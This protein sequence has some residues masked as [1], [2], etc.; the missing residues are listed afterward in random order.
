MGNISDKLQ[1]LAETKEAI[2]EA[3]KAKGVTID[4]NAPFRK[5]A[6]SIRS[7][8]AETTTNDV[9]LYDYDGKCLYSYSAEAFL[10]LTALPSPPYREGKTAEWNWALSD[11]QEVVRECGLLDIGVQYKFNDNILCKLYLS[12]KSH[13]QLT[14]EIYG[15]TQTSRIN[16]GDGQEIALNSNITAETYAHTYEHIGEYCITIYGPAYNPIFQILGIGQ[17]G[18][19][20][21]TL[22]AAELGKIGLVER[23]FQNCVGLRTVMLSGETALAGSP[24]ENCHNLSAVVNPYDS[25]RGK[26]AG[27]MKGC[28]SL[29]VCALNKQNYPSA[30]Y[31]YGCASLRRICFARDLIYSQVNGHAVLAK[32]CTALTEVVLPSSME[33]ID[34]YAF[35]NCLSLTYISIPPSVVEVK[36]VPFAGCSSLAVI[37]FSSHTDIPTSNEGGIGISSRCKIIVPDAL[38]DE[39]IAAA[40]WSNYASQIIKASEYNG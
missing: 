23:G 4:D 18:I 14:F 28:A 9:N 29:R 38:Y 31:F 20:N 37:D 19:P 7:I 8:V 10:Q 6:D 3:I 33:L 25:N 32:N 15:R 5:Y 12:I 13:D 34:D 2:K 24:F 16:W 40:N 22:V 11:A 30:S 36:N 35:E 17:D 27:I 39:W 21:T 26:D 1:Y